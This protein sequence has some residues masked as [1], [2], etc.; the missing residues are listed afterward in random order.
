[1]NRRYVIALVGAGNI[2]SRHL[3]GLALSRLDADIH[4]VEPNEAAASLATERLAQVK[5]GANL[6]FSFHRALNDLP[7]VLDVA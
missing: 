5:A 3:Q 2:G 6:R 4:I 7:P 1:M